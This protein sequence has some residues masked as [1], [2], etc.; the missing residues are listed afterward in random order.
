VVRGY[1]EITLVSILTRRSKLSLLGNYRSKTFG[2]GNDQEGISLFILN[3]GQ[4]R[5]FY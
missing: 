2:A 3:D 1:G 5:D 4:N